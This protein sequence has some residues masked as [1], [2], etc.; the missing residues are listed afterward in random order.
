MLLEA[1]VGAAYE[2]RCAEVVERGKPDEGAG[3]GEEGRAWAS[4]TEARTG[5]RDMRTVEG[6]TGG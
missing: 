5:M 4:S 1:E 2:A 3:E 6:R